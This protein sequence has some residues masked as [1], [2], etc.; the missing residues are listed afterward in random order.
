MRRYLEPNVSKLIVVLTVV[1]ESVESRGGL[2][3]SGAQG[4]CSERGPRALIDLL[5]CGCLLDALLSI[6]APRSER[7]QPG[8]PG[9]W[10]IPPM[11]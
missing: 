1:K 7:H 4:H 6:S 10:L 9:P 11:P 3:V 2:R 5:G 8:G